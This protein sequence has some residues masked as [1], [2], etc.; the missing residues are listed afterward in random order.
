MGTYSDF[1]TRAG[2]SCNAQATFAHG[3]GAVPDYVVIQFSGTNF[4]S[5]GG[6][7]VS[8]T[9]DAVGVTLQAAC[10]DATVFTPNMKVATVVAHTIVR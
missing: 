2:L 3:L 4:I 8:A 7:S 10:N 6:Y 1:R 5:T 9:A